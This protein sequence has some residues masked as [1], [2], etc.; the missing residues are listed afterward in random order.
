MINLIGKR[1]QKPKNVGLVHAKLSQYRIEY[2]PD[3][4]S[5]FSSIVVII[6]IVINPSKVILNHQNF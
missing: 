1:G 3:S 4:N 5:I 6:K 2:Y